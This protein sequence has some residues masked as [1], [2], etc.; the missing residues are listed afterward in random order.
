[1]SAAALVE[2]SPELFGTNVVSQCGSS[3]SKPGP[4]C[5]QNYSI[6]HRLFMYLSV[7]FVKTEAVIIFYNQRAEVP[8][9][10]LSGVEKGGVV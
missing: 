2:I 8:I 9:S 5:S 6:Y 7:L 1:M 4:C 10:I 3:I